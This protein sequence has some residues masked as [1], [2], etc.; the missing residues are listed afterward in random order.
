MIGLNRS[1]DTIKDRSYPRRLA[2]TGD[3]LQAISF[4]R[5]PQF[6]GAFF[7]PNT[8]IDTSVH[9]KWI[10]LNVLNKLAR[11]STA[12]RI[13]LILKAL[14]ENRACPRAAEKCMCM[15]SLQMDVFVCPCCRISRDPLCLDIPLR[16]L[17]SN[18]T[19]LAELFSVCFS[20]SLAP[21]KMNLLAWRGVIVHLKNPTQ[22]FTQILLQTVQPVALLPFAGTGRKFV[23]EMHH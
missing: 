3:I 17:S 9:T 11:F 13:A 23:N 10:E 18:L 15:F 20:I 6:F 8:H 2:S 1:R 12:K 16:Q 22:S 7:V 5:H 21:T 14:S 4:M 19:D